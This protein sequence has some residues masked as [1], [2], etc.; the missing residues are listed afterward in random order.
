[1]SRVNV[2]HLAVIIGIRRLE[3]GRIAFHYQ[4]FEGNQESDIIFKRNVNV[5][6]EVSLL[7]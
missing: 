7:L 2:R 4:F 6:R 3:S 5:Q 1:M